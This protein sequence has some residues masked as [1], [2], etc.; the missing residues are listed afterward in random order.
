MLRRSFYRGSLCGAVLLV[1]GLLWFALDPK[2][3]AR[4]HL[5][6]RAVRAID[7]APGLVAR[8]RDAA[9]F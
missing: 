6:D 4:Q 3:D 9:R 2:G 5:I 8:L 1:P 7:A